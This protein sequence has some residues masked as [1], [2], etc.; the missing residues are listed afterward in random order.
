MRMVTQR[1]A[2]GTKVAHGV[3]WQILLCLTPFSDWSSQNPIM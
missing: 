3:I 2:T 1:A